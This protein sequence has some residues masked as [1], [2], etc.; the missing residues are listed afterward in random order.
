[1]LPLLHF[2]LCSLSFGPFYQ[3]QADLSVL[4]NT[5]QTCQN[6]RLSLVQPKGGVIAT[7]ILLNC[8]TPDAKQKDVELTH[9]H[10]RKRSG[11]H[12]SISRAAEGMVPVAVIGHY[13]WFE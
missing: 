5:A 9:T 12:V 3:P 7:Q 2:S 10:T 1:M 8:Y 4:A 6:F 13:E 11:K